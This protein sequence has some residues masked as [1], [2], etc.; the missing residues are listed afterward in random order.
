MISKGTKLYSIIH[1]KCP[2]CHEG[3]LFTSPWYNINHFADMHEHCP[4]CGLRYEHEPN[5]FFGAMFV[6]YAFQV[7]LMVATYIVLFFFNADYW[8]YII[9]FMSAI[10]LTVPIS[11]RSA[12]SMW[13]NI[14]VSYRE[15]KV[16]S[17]K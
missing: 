13:I 11:F 12:R 7:A 2:R 14:F 8:V 1:E 9:T 16:E 4:Q 17:R 3:N 10:I 15:Q 6:S 5:F